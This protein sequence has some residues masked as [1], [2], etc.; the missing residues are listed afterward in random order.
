MSNPATRRGT[1][2]PAT[3]AAWKHPMAELIVSEERR[4]WILA[5]YPPSEMG[6]PVI[7][8]CEPQRKSRRAKDVRNNADEL[9][10][11]AA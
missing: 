4:L 2:H 6:R 1:M 8:F 10:E 7:L 5:T 3:L 9:A 11:L